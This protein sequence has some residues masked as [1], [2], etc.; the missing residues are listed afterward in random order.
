VA[1]YIS[2]VSAE[3]CR[4]EGVGYLDLAGNCRLSFE[5]VFIRREGIHN[6]FAV[7]RDL[8]SLYAAKSA[9]VL[10]VLLMRNREW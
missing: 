9:R 5:N 4:K 6:P 3:I 2:P 10:R 7:K 1:P 8:R